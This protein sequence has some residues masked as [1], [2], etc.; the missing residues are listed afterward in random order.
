MEFEGFRMYKGSINCYNITLNEVFCS[1]HE[2][3]NLFSAIQFSYTECKDLI[4]SLIINYY[5]IN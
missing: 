1:K 4:K 5:I 3:K 2:K